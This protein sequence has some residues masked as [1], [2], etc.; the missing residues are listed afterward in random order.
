MIRSTRPLGCGHLI[1]E[2]VDLRR[3][4]EAEHLARV[5]GGEVAAAGDLEAAARQPPTDHVIVAPTRRGCTRALQ[6][7]AHPVI[8]VAGV[9]LQQHRRAAV[10]ADENVHPA[11]VVVVADRQA[12]RRKASGRPDRLRR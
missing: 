2:P 7:H 5:V 10:V 12:P 6:L 9:V 11:V 8:A 4:A 3:G 1:F